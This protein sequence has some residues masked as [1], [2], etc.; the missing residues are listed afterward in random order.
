MTLLSVHEQAVLQRATES[1]WRVERQLKEATLLIQ[2]ADRT[3]GKVSACVP[4]A[5]EFVGLTEALWDYFR[6]SEGNW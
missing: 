2:R 3:D 6:D 4:G 1:P 5:L